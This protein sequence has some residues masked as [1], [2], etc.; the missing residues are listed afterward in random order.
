MDV[1]FARCAG[2]DVHK[3]SVV[4][5]VRFP[6]PRPG[7]RGRETQTF[8]TTLRELRELAAWLTRH[9]VTHVAMES[10]GVYWRP[11][12]AVLEGAL[13]VLLVNARHVKQ[14]PGR[15]TDVRDCEWLRS[16][17]NVGCCAAASCRRAPCAICAT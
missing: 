14:L 3:K 16:C 13:T 9:G 17:S 2:L 4:G 10:T 7:E 15:K 11:V 12:Y 8:G 6:G 1:M 5:C